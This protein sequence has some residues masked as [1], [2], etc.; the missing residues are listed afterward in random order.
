LAAFTRWSRVLG[1]DAVGGSPHCDFANEGVV[2]TSRSSPRWRT[3]TLAGVILDLLGKV[4]DKFGSPCQ[5]AAPDRIGMQRC[6]NAWEPGQRT[7]VG[8]RERREAPVEDGRHIVCGSKVAS[9]GGCQQVMEWM[10]AGFRRQS[11]QVGSKGR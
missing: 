6:W 11:E 5:V 4:G 9:A 3:A 2:T 10:L 7:S 8:R 1:I